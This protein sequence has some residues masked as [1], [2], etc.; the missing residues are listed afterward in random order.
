MIVGSAL[1]VAGSPPSSA[2]GSPGAG[3]L[4]MRMTGC[5]CLTPASAFVMMR[6]TQYDDVEAS[7]FQSCVVSD[8]FH[9]VMPRALAC[10][11]VFASKSPYGGRNTH[12]TVPTIASCSAV[13]LSISAPCC[14]PDSVDRC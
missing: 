5:C 3:P 11:A 7:A 6:L 10:G 9:T 2:G 1:T 13:V 4:C 8:Q 14:G 12:G